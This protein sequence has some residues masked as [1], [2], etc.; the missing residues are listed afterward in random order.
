MEFD[1]YFPFTGKDGK[2]RPGVKPMRKQWNDIVKLSESGDI[3]Q[4]VGKFRETKDGYIKTCLPAVCYMGKCYGTRAASNM[5][6]TQVISIDVDHVND[7][8]TAYLEVLRGCDRTWWSENVLL[9]H[10]TPS[11]HG[12]RFVVWAQEEFGG[13]VAR[14][15]K[16]LSDKMGLSN[17]GDVDTPARTL[18]GCPLCLMEMSSYMLANNSWVMVS[19]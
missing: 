9:A 4:L 6:P 17:Y 18:A 14:Q 8:A 19:K 11:G 10:I 15:I 3:K 12:L 2:K 1:V 5:E 13:D 16:G 7:P